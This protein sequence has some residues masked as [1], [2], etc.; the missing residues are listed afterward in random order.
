MTLSDPTLSMPRF[1]CCASADRAEAVAR[2]GF[3]F[4]ELPAAGTLQADADGDDFAPAL[5]MLEHLPIPAEAFNVFLP[6]DLKI[7]GEAVDKERIRRYVHHAM[8]R[9]SAVGGK[10]MVFGSGGARRVPEGFDPLEALAQIAEFLSIV[11][12]EAERFDVA[13]AIEPLNQGETN[14]INSVTEGLEL[15]ETVDHPSIRVLAD[16]YHMEVERE[17]LDNVLPVGDRLAHVHVADT[18]RFS[19]GTGE[20]DTIGLFRRLKQIGYTGRVSIECTWRD[21]E[22]EAPASLAFLRETWQRA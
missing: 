10:V 16:L 13:I 18:G 17:P 9:A 5:S 7:V 22:A 19:P 4:I 14:I 8:D 11:G 12:P 1:G 20:Y 21:F 3:D 6:G 2:A 15:A